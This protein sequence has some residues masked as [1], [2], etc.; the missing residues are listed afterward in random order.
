MSSCQGELPDTTF[1]V[2]AADHGLGLIGAVARMLTF[3]KAKD[4]L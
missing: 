3:L 2:G 1:D 4:A